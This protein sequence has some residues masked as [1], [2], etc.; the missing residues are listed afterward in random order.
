M[1]IH[2]I[3]KPKHIQRKHRVG[4]GGKRGTYSGRG[5]KGQK[6][7][8]GHN[9]RPQIWDY[10]KTIPKL[11][12]PTNKSEDAK[13]W[14]GKTP[15]PVFVVNLQDLNNVVKS[16]DQVTPAY[17]LEKGVIP[18]YKGRAP[19]KVKLL[20]KGEIKKKV[21]IEGI[22]ASNPAKKKIEEA[23]GSITYS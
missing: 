13:R 23:G 2:E 18:K 15:A 17:L 9:I 12:G 5:I 22:E 8:E 7:R 4:R 16:G 1:Q 14:R 19:K 10:I 20:A 21:N 6:A 3:R 11:K